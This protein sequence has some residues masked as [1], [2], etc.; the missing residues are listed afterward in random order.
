MNAET[1]LSVQNLTVDYVTDDGV[2]RAVRGL[3]FDLRR[4]EIFGLLGESGSG[5]STA[6]M[7]LVRLLG[8]PAVISGGSVRF[9]GRDVLAMSSEALRAFRFREISIVLQSSMNALCPT[10]TIGAQIEDT[11]ACH[12]E[13]TRS[14]TRSRVVSSLEL[15]GLNERHARLFPH[16]LS[17]GMR[18]R[19][20]IAIALALRPKMIILDEP[21][22]ALDVVLQREILTEVRALQVELGFS[23]LLISH[24]L[25]LMLEFCDQ[26]GVMYAGKLVERASVEAMR[27]LPRHPYTLGLF[28]S[29]PALKGPRHRLRGVPGSPPHLLSL[30]PGCA[31]LPRCA[32]GDSGCTNGILSLQTITQG[33]SVACLKVSSEANDAK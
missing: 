20:S 33:H 27:T 12:G 17:G 31:F 19:A 5:K 28:Q 25:S 15:V 4:G 22:T 2:A 30:P 23:I 29:F 32:I 14:E 7:A 8:P 3:S 10:L 9:E 26:I 18:Q 21:T 11:L 13:L 24:D 6:A 1:L 16:Q